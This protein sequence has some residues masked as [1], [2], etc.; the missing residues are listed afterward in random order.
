M[1]VEGNEIENVMLNSQDEL[2]FCNG[3]P[4]I[5]SKKKITIDFVK[6]LHTPL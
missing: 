2:I 3:N 5:E 4:M 6:F 1:K